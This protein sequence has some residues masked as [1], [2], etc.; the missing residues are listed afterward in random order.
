M[1]PVNRG[2]QSFREVG[3]PSPV[4]DLFRLIPIIPWETRGGSE[5]E[6]RTN[7]D[8]GG[9]ARLRLSWGSRCRYNVGRDGSKRG[10]LAHGNVGCSEFLSLHDF[11]RNWREYAE[12]RW[13]TEDGLLYRDNRPTLTWNTVLVDRGLQDSSS[14]SKYSRVGW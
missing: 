4:A 12:V 8:R 9:R 2:R 11:A 3:L 6:D 10:G 5:R 7:R 1:L 13:S 14:P